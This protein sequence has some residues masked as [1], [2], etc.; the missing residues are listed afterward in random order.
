MT[1]FNVLKYTIIVLYKKNGT[2]PA[3]G[4]FNID[5]YLN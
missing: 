5:N 3:D 2:K 1:I 4:N